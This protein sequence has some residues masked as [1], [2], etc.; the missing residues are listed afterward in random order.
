MEMV[1]FQFLEDTVQARSL[2]WLNELAQARPQVM[3]HLCSTMRSILDDV[4]LHG[5][6]ATTLDAA[7]TLL[8]TLSSDR[9]YVR[10]LNLNTNV[11]D[12]LEGK[13]FGGSGSRAQW[14]QWRTTSATASS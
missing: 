10:Q 1:D 11:A 9:R 2:Q 8:R 4:L 13:G 3:L 12:V 5:Q 14:V 7:H 6:N